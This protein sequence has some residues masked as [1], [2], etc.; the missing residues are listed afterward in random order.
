M[1]QTNQNQIPSLSLS[2]FHSWTVSSFLSMSGSLPANECPVVVYPGLRKMKIDFDPV[3]RIFG[4]FLLA[5]ISM[6]YASVLQ[7]YIY[8]SA[9]KSIHVWIQAPAYVLVALSEAFI[10]ITGLEIAFT[11][12][13]KKYVLPPS[14]PN[15]S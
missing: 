11:Q 14:Y 10:I 12:A 9:P 13:P 3:S 2:S 7:H 8:N 15:S 5:S 1:L 6:V 4:G